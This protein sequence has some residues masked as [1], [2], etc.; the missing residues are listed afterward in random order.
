MLEHGVSMV[1]VICS[2]GTCAAVPLYPYIVK[3]LVL[4]LTKEITTPPPAEVVSRLSPVAFSVL[5]FVA[6]IVHEPE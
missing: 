5:V 6:L 1:Y 3:V 2:F 4:A